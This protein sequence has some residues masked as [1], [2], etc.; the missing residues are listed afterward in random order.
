MKNKI[1][2]SNTIHQDESMNEV[3]ELEYTKIK[4]LGDAGLTKER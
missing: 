2:V 1:M 4:S 3:P